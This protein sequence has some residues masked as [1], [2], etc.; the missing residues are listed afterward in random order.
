MRNRFQSQNKKATILLSHLS[1][2][3]L[4]ALPQKKSCFTYSSMPDSVVSQT[5][6]WYLCE[7]M[8][9]DDF[10]GLSKA[11]CVYG[12]FRQTKCLYIGQSKRGI[13]RIFTHS[14]INVVEPLLPGDEIRI[15]WTI[16]DHVNHL[17]SFLIDREGP[18]YNKSPGFGDVKVSN[19]VGSA[20]CSS[21][22]KEFWQKFWWQTRCIGPDGKACQQRLKLR[23]QS[24]GTTRE[25]LLVLL[26][27]P[28]VSF[29]IP[30]AH[31]TS[32]VG[33]TQTQR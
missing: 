24:D 4:L 1:E 18:K 14:I 32:P 5:D 3:K 16:P 2:Q 20:I 17:E 11:Y 26:A 15:I 27:L 25:E 33:E 19:S 13:H 21:C 6:P 9:Y 31:T 7:I 22:G 29:S 28:P 30:S 12:W 8:T 23:T 10:F